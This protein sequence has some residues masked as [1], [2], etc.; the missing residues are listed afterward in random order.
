LNIDIITCAEIE[1]LEGTSGNFSVTVNK[2]PRY[3]D[4]LKCTGCGDCAEACPVDLIDEYDQGLSLRKATY[5]KYAQAVPGAYAIQKVDQAP[6]R[7]A[8]P[9]DIN[10][11]GYVQMVKQG[12][13]EEALK[14]I[15]EDL[16]LPGVIGRICPHGC[17]DACRRSEVDEPVAIRTLKRLAADHFDPRDIKIP[18]LPERK[19]KVAVIGSGP[20]GLS[21]AYQLARKGIKSVIFEELPKAGGMLRVGIPDHR[22]PPEILDREIEVI[23]NLGVEIKTG[24]ALDENMTVDTLFE[25]GF[26]AVFLAV[27]THKGYT[28]GLSGENADGVRQGVDFLRELNLTG[29]VKVGKKVVVVGGGNVAIDVSR[30]AIRLGAEEVTILYRRTRAEMPAWE[31]EIHAAEEEGVRITFLATPEEVLTQEG[32][33]TGIRC[34]RMELGEPDDSGRRRPVPVQGSQYDIQV[35]QLIPAIG[36][37]AFSE[38]AETTGLEFSKWGK[39]NVDPVTYATDRKGVFA[40]GD[41]QTGPDVAI[42]AI[43]AGKETA[44]SIVRYIDGHDMAAGRK[45]VTMENPVYRPI[46]QEVASASRPKMM[47]ETLEKRMASFNEAELGF[48]EEDGK[49]EADRCLNCGYC[50]ECYQCVEAC[51]ADAVTIETHAEKSRTIELKV[52]SIIMAPGFQAFDPSKFDTYNY[53]SHPN[54]ITSMEMERFLS[55]SGPTMGHLVRPSDHKEPKKIAWFQCVGS[56]DLNRCDNSF[57]SSVCCM[58]AIKEAVIAKE[59]A[60]DDLE[61]TIFFMDMRTHGKDFERYYDNAKINHGIRFIRSRVHTIDSVRGTDDL[62]VRYISEQGEIKNETF[63]QVV[64]S[65]GLQT[66][67]EVLDLAEKLGI[68]TTDGNFCKTDS[69]EPV[70]TSHEGIFVCGAFQGP[71][72]IPQSVI[73]ASAAACAAGEELSA[74][75]NTRTKTKE[76]VPETNVTGERPRIGV[77]VCKC[78]INIAGVVDVPTVRDF[79]AQLPYVE[80]VTDNLYTC[81]QDTQDTMTQVI[82]EKQLNRVVVAACTPKTHEPLFQETLTN[83][84]LNKYL[85][86]MCNIR[87]QDSWVHK[88]NPELA[89]GKA[90]DLVRMAVAKVALMSPLKEAELEVN[91]TAMVI[92]GGISGITAAKSLSRQGYETHVV[93]KSA[94]LGGQALH[95][96]RTYQGEDVQAKLSDLVEQVEQDAK[97]HIHLNTSIDHVEGF[98]GNFSTT[99]VEDGDKNIVEHGVAVMATGATQSTPEEYSYGKDQRII[100]SQELA[101]KFSDNDSALKKLNSAVFIQCVGSREPER[102]YCSRVCCTQS[103]YNALTLKEMNPEMNIFIL[104]RD[105]RTYGEREYL[106]KKARE[107]GII[108]IRYSLENKPEVVLENGEVK[109]KTTDHVLGLPL[110]LSADMITLATAIVPNRDDA[111]AQFF[112]LPVN[113]DGFYIE[114]HAKLGPS[115]FATDGVFLC[116]M[117]HYPKPIDE[118]IVQSK[119]AASRAVTLL[120][121]KNIFTSGTVAE[122]S[123][124][125]CS[126]CGTCVSICPYSAPFFTKEGPF[127]GKAE[128]NPVLCKGCGLCVA[129]CRSGALHLKGFDNDQIFE[130]IFSMNQAVK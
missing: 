40:G 104:Y 89:T 82:R 12:K 29:S 31:E 123:P 72:D 114:R 34:I 37:T 10:V 95:L 91:Q 13:Y 32:R 51:G 14:I 100:T 9:A 108:F 120:A 124:L 118:S 92:G 30:A 83:A 20:A 113:D 107:Q 96:Y 52:G 88:N 47:E 46:P 127:A 5:K 28:L 44:E 78:G 70:A 66:P 4:E 50:C 109:V 56:R 119:A 115:E 94:R 22:L 63:D 36:Q 7:M 6:C 105:I 73:D 117:A 81:S 128:I 49:K 122:T 69:F 85:F 58:Y 74:A 42:R 23:T 71:K 60:G 99:L 15:M 97:I 45:P 27:G 102:P 106:Y 43:A 112:K 2:T 68:E 1:K 61:C 26:K 8:C 98:V 75:R 62:S 80:Y 21:A 39:L 35:D 16:P 111:L 18:C 64:L 103:I 125:Y 41:V 59:H 76:V 84:G 77:F 110:E 126:S 54:V 116:G 17:E 87:N 121:R 130:Q 129:S 57:C 55:A 24:V 93:E 79:A 90:K 67:Q 25:Q 86:E 53:A 3:I 11:Q 19:E 33:I 38:L 65:V 48:N 101:I